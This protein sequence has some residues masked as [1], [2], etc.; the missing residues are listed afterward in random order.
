MVEKKCFI[1]EKK[2]YT[3]LVF[4]VL[5][6]FMILS[7]EKEKAPTED[8]NTLPMASFFYKIQYG[9]YTDGNTYA[10][11][12][13]TNNSAYSN[14]WK[15]SRPGSAVTISGEATFMTNK[16][17]AV[18]QVYAATNK[19]QR[20]KITLIAYSDVIVNPDSIKTFESH[21]FV[22]EVVVKKSE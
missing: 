4:T 11:V 12:T 5:V 20:F 13:A 9:T 2:F 21:P 22:Q 14:R 15:W 19:E 8:P 18:T 6:S 10:Y 7:C 3:T 16:D 1:S 17:T